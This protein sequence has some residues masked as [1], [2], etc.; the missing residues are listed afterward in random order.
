MKEK[1]LLTGK[2]LLIVDDE[3]DVLDS[4]SELLDVCEVKK[5]TTFDEAKTLLETEPFDLAVLDIMGVNGYGLLKVANEKRVTA[6]MLTAHGLAPENL[7]RAQK[8]GAA[9]FIPKEEIARIALFLEDVLEAIEKGKSTWSRW[10]ER[11]EGYFD[12]KYGPEWQ[13]RHRITVR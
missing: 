9:Y 2:R 10:I 7:L 1:S 8:E 12:R 13:K 3:P 4:L 5:A 6:V 11:F